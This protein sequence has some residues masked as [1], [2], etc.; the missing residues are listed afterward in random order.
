MRNGARCSI[1]AGGGSQ[2]ADDLPAAAA[3]SCPNLRGVMRHPVVS[4][5]ILRIEIIRP[6]VGSGKK[7]PPQASPNFYASRL[8]KAAIRLISPPPP[9]TPIH[10]MTIPNPST[11]N[12]FADRPS[13]F[14]VERAGQPDCG[15]AAGL[16]EMHR[17]ASAA[18]SLISFGCIS[19]LLLSRF[20]TSSYTRWT[21]AESL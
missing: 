7:E 19:H 3:P 11:R 21:Y 20:C 14:R 8:A 6:T 1:Q 5:L 12:R 2:F 9:A 18:L 15:R 4:P 16:C 13:A 10:S 17:P